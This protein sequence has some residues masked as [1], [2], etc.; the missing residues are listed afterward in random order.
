MMRGC[1]TALATPFKDGGIDWVSLERLLKRQIEGGV[2]GIVPCGTT[3]E[4]PVLSEEEYVE[5]IRRSIAGVDR[6]ILVMAGLSGN[7]TEKLIIQAK[8]VAA[9]GPDAFLV[10]TPYYNKP[11]QRGLYEHYARLAQ[12]IEIPICLYNVPSRTGVNM[13]PETVLALAR[14]FPQI[15]AVKEA[16]G[17]LD[18]VSVICRGAPSGFCVLSGDD[19]LTLPVL[20]VGGT[21]VVSVASNVAAFEM[22]A[23]VSAWDQMDQDK[24]RRIHG[25][26]FPLFKALFLETSPAP[27]KCALERLGIFNSSEVRLPLVACSSETVKKIDDALRQAGLL[28]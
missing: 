27:V 16:S 7:S 25:K 17:S 8:R 12:A 23:L 14:E 13:E 9:L 26:L 24:A 28:H 3:G 18:Q 20:A 19:S 22:S 1:W 4:T 6:K 21:G 2:G 10:V 5:V 15:K 11:T